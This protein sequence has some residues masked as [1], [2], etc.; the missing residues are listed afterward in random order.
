MLLWTALMKAVPVENTVQARIARFGSI[1]QSETK[2][3]WKVHECFQFNLNLAPSTA[4]E[5][6]FDA[7][8]ASLGDG[9]ERHDISDEE[10]WAVW[11]RKEESRF[12]ALHVR[13]AHVERFPESAVV[14]S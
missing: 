13:W 6:A 5:T 9:W 1:K 10:Q 2:H 12:F 14:Q 11:N 3:Y 7:I 4:P 8:L